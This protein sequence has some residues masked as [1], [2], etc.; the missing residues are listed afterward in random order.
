MASSK[1]RHDDPCSIKDLIVEEKKKNQKKKRNPFIDDEA[2]ETHGN[3]ADDENK[4]SDDEPINADSFDDEEE[5][6]VLEVIPCKTKK[7]TPN[8]NKK[9]KGNTPN[10]Q[11]V[12]EFTVG[13][14][15]LNVVSTPVVRRSTTYAIN[16]PEKNKPSQY[17][18]NVTEDDDDED[19]D[20]KNLNVPTP[21]GKPKSILDKKY[22]E[23]TSIKIRRNAIIKSIITI[24]HTF[25]FVQLSKDKFFAVKFSLEDNKSMFYLWK[26]TATDDLDNDDHIYRMK[27]K[28]YSKMMYLGEKEFLPWAYAIDH[29]RHKFETKTLKRYEKEPPSP[30]DIEIDENYTLSTFKY[31]NGVGGGI[32]LSPTTDNYQAPKV[33]LGFTPAQFYL[34]VETCATFVSEIFKDIGKFCKELKKKENIMDIAAEEYRWEQKADKKPE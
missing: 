28:A 33:T 20:P 15:P 9:S 26:G 19:E 32:A 10:V 27:S 11:H 3:S 25:P 21:P 12:G 8:T 16:N 29:Y 23:D 6:E 24:W 34:L 17:Y 31:K 14:I 22:L 30:R 13:P 5:D 7:M 2:K 4:S 18:E 1:R